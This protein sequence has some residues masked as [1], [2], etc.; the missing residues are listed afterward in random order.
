MDHHGLIALARAITFDLQAVRQS[1]VQE[2][3][4]FWQA[5]PVIFPESHCPW[6]NGVMRSPYIWFLQGEKYEKLIGAFKP[7]AGGKVDLVYP[8]HAH[9]GA[10]LC[11]GH[12]PN[13]IALL[14]ST[15]NLADCFMPK[16][17]IPKW[18]KTY[19]DHRCEPMRAF[20]NEYDNKGWLRE[21]DAL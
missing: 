17:C 9:G 13:G 4:W 12:N 5:T 18:L 8:S 3:Q 19:W 10:P 6:C 2:T 7:I 21:L 11:L 14:A 15:V 20:L 1:R 16:T